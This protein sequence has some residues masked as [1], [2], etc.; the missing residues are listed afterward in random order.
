MFWENLSPLSNSD[1]YWEYLD[2][3]IKEKIFKLL[4]KKPL[5]LLPI[6]IYAASLSKYDKTKKD[7]TAMQGTGTALLHTRCPVWY[8]HTDCQQQQKIT[9]TDPIVRSLYGVVFG[10]YQQQRTPYSRGTLSGFPS[11]RS[12]C[13]RGC[14]A[15]WDGNLTDT[16]SI[17]DGTGERTPPEPILMGAPTQDPKSITAVSLCVCECVCVCIDRKEWWPNN[18]HY[19]ERNNSFLLLMHLQYS[20]Y[21]F[22]KINE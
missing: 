1:T 21:I 20:V 13:Q 8:V 14:A 19:D 16:T 7:V 22:F 15:V 5:L 9:R 6:S 12:R 2:L 4:H 18:N 11:V 3:Y 10:R 17:E